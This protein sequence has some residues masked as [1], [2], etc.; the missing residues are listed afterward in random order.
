MQDQNNNEEK[1]KGI[2][3]G[4]ILW[5]V[6]TV[7]ILVA[8]GLLSMRTSQEDSSD[9]LI[10]SP[11]P[12]ISTQVE[13]G[14]EEAQGGGPSVD[15]VSLIAFAEQDFDGRDFT[16]GR[17]LAEND[18]YT[19]RYITYKSGELTISGIMNIPKGSG[20]FPLLLLNHG[21]IDT[22]IYTNGR[23]LKREQDYLARRGYVVIHSDYRGH[24]ESDDDPNTDQRFRLGY[25]EDVINAIVAVKKAQLPY[26]DAERVGMLGHSMGGGVAW[27]I[28]VT[29]PELVDAYVQFAPVSADERDNFEKWTKSRPEVAQ[30]IIDQYKNPA[31][32]PAFWDNISPISFFRN[33]AVPVMIHHGTTDE[34]VPLAWSERAAK[35]LQ[36][37]QKNTVFHIYPNEPHE[38]I[39]AWPTV[40]QRTVSFFDEHVK[41]K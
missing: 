5:I 33:I 26:V 16:V 14:V 3:L 1:H 35:A 13:Q 37:V 17:V 18:A 38:F 29:Q 7:I 11:I 41:N 22:S 6:G 21:Y 25:A 36:D 39:D 2:R 8:I 34:S 19:R 10:S 24:A 31:D 12:D 30:R 4:A 23:G 28:A 27:R 32:N 20:P 9:D 15:S 40:M